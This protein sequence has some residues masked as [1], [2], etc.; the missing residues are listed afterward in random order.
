MINMKKIII[1]ILTCILCGCSNDSLSKEELNNIIEENNYIIIDVRT[2]EEYDE[3]HIK[4]SINIPYNEINAKDID[5][6][7]I[8][9]VYC[10]SGKR[11]EIAYN[12]LNELGYTV[13][14]LGSINNIELEKATE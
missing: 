6:S 7:K 12:K 4:D 11:S 9:L 3:S 1:L 10:A 5:K 14:D 2:E 8:I 13:Y